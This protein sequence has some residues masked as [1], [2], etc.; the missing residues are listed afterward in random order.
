MKYVSNNVYE[1]KQMCLFTGLHFHLFVLCRAQWKFDINY[2]Y[3]G[4]GVGGF[5][6][7]RKNKIKIFLYHFRVDPTPTTTAI[8]NF[9]GNVPSTLVPQ[10]FGR[11]PGGTS[12]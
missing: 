1:I 8:P 11:R 9:I 3:S 7:A 6:P 10:T 5:A 4:V 2:M 12:S